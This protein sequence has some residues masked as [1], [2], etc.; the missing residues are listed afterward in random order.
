[1]AAVNHTLWVFDL[2]STTTHLSGNQIQQLPNTIN[3]L[4]NFFLNTVVDNIRVASAVAV[5]TTGPITSAGVF[6]A[7]VFL[8]RRSE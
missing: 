3:T 8:V 2:A 4:N 5:A 6:D 7:V 1:M